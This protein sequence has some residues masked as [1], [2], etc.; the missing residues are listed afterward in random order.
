MPESGDRR[1]LIDGE[2]W[3]TCIGFPKS[4]RLWWIWSPDPTPD[5]I[6]LAEMTIV[7]DA[8][9]K[10]VCFQCPGAGGE[11]I[12]LSLSQMQ[13]LRWTP[14]SDWL[15]RPTRSPTLSL[16]VRQLNECRCFDAAKVHFPPFVAA[17]RAIEN[18][19]RT[20]WPLA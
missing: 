12:K 3:M 20:I 1:W 10:W 18:P 6:T 2:A 5:Q 7:R 4:A 8:V 11:T 19:T 9:D 15:N 13:R 17:G 14:I 16:S